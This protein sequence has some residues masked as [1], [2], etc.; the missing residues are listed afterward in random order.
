MISALPIIP[1]IGCSA[2]PGLSEVCGA[3]SSVGTSILGAGAGDVLGSIAGGVAQGASWLLGQ[4][5]TVIGSSTTIDL[6]ASWFRAHYEVMVGLAA[7]VLV[8]LLLASVIQAIY[9]QSASSLLRTA[10]VHLPLALLLGAVAVQLVQLGLAATDALSTAV[11]STSSSNVGSALSS[12]ASSLAGQ[13]SA[14]IPGT[15]TFVALLGGLFVCFGALLLWVELLVRAAAV[16]VATL[17]FPLALA[18]LVWPAISQ[19]C[20]RLV[21]TV[22]ALVLSKFV[23]VAVLSLAVGALGTSDGSIASELAGGALLLLAGFAPFTL[24]RLVPMVESG[25]VQQ[26]EGVRH[27]VQQHALA[28]PRSAIGYALGHG[29]PMPLPELAP[30]TAMAAVPEA[31]GGESTGTGGRTGTQD[32]PTTDPSDTG[33][34][35][36]QGVADAAAPRPAV[37]NEGAGKSGSPPVW[38]APLSLPTRSPGRNGTHTVERDDLGPVLRWRPSSPPRVDAPPD[39]G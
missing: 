38:G 22:A 25:A 8:P 18:S 36:W 15:P 23:I 10:L 4:I 26:L 28:G 17:F 21:E 13:A 11:S 14:G 31:P 12:L 34:P 29:A 32:P 7:V 6:G 37:A 30:G 39:G 19:W 3:A 1:S 5:G 2:I 20:R 24:L 9:H 33:V 35:M 27:R 16:Y